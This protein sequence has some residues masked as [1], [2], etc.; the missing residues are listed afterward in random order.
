[1]TQPFS[2]WV[3]NQAQQLILATNC[4]IA[5]YDSNPE[6]SKIEGEKLCNG[7]TLLTIIGKGFGFDKDG[8]IVTVTQEYPPQELKRKCKY[9]QSNCDLQLLDSKETYYCDELEM[10]YQDELIQCIVLSPLLDSRPL[11]VSVINLQHNPPKIASQT[12]FLVY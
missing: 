6:I 2:L 8:L 3:R 11:E 9:P 7:E 5:E 10:I 4:S 12:T 1:M